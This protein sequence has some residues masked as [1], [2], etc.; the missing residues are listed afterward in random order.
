MSE[1]YFIRLRKII[2]KLDINL[3]TSEKLFLLTLESEELTK[4]RAFK[5]LQYN[6]S[7]TKQFKGK[8]CYFIYKDVKY[9]HRKGEGLKL[10]ANVD[11][12]FLEDQIVFFDKKANGYVNIIKYNKIRQIKKHNYGIQIF[13]G[14]STALLRYGELNVIYITI[15]R[16]IKRYDN[17]HI[18]L[19]KLK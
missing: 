17:N 4:K 8:K 10:I 19:R 5:T 1:I 18:V 12:F 13:A 3:S 2:V 7:N 11:L 14:M 9:Y 15:M 16:S 6:F